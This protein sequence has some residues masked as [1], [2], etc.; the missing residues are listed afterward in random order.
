MNIQVGKEVRVKS[1]RNH[2]FLVTG[3]VKKITD[4]FYFVKFRPF[5]NESDCF[6]IPFPKQTLKKSIYS[7]LLE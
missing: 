4:T 1:I 6:I 7:I 5:K 3:I 2:D